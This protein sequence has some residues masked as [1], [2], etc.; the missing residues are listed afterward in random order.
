MSHSSPLPD[1]GAAIDPGTGVIMRITDHLIPLFALPGIDPTLARQMAIT[2]LAAY[3]PENPADFVNVARTIAFSMAALALLGKA[4]APNL[5]IAEQM[6]AYGRANALN[7]SA[8]Q[9]ERTMMQRRH[10][11]TTTARALQPHPMHPDTCLGEND[12]DFD[13]AAAEAAIDAA[14][15]E[16]LSAYRTQP[17]APDTRTIKPDSAAATPNPATPPP[18]LSVTIP[19]PAAVPPEAAATPLC[20][21]ARRAADPRQPPF[22]VAAN[23]ARSNAAG[24]AH[25]PRPRSFKDALMQQSTMHRTDPAGPNHHPG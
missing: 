23:P 22:A 20:T 25:F 2:A 10:H 19:R 14:V 18:H 5:P 1:P 9:S 16:A 8:D 7:R 15:A 17:A 11:Q 12:E 3:Q 21:P 6:R 13:T 24:F 4:A